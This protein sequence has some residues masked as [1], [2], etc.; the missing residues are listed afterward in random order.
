MVMRPGRH[1]VRLAVFSAALALVATGASAQESSEL[2]A[3]SITSAQPVT[4]EEIRFT[5]GKGP[6]RGNSYLARFE[7]DYSYLRDP[8]RSTD[9]FDP[10]KF[11]P[12]DSDSDFY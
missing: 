12:F 6:G 11:V 10:L 4:G 2:P 1:T 9:F 5:K 3:K 8:A 7:E